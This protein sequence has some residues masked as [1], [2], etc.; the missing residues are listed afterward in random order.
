MGNIKKSKN[1]NKGH[2]PASGNQSFPLIYKI[3]LAVVLVLTLIVFSNT[4]KNDFIVNWDDDGYVLN[5]PTIQH[6]DKASVKEIFSSFHM[7]NYHP[8]TTLTYAIEYDKFKVNPKPY[9]CINLILHLLNVILVF[10]FVKGLTKKN[11][12]ALITCALFAIHPMHVESV[13]WISELKD[14]LYTFF[15]LLSLMLYTRFSEK[16]KL[17]LYF[18]SLVMFFLSLLSKSAAVVLPLVLLLID[19][20]QNKKTDIKN[21]LLK[22]PFFLLAILLGIIALKSQDAQAQHLTPNYSLFN[23]FFVAS[24]ALGF[25]IL[26][27]FIPIQLSAFYPHP[28][29]TGSTLPIIYYLSPLIIAGFIYLTFR[30]IKEKKLILFCLLFLFVTIALVLQFFPVGGAVVADRYTYVPYIGLAFLLAVYAE[31]IYLSQKNKQSKLTVVFLVIV[32]FCSVLSFNRNSVWANGVV[33]FDDVIEKQPDAFYAYHSRGIAYY[34]TGNYTESLK[35]YNKAI[36]L[37]NTYGLTFYNRGL[38]QMML[39][40]YEEASQSFS[41]TIEL[42]PTHDQ[43]YNDRAIARYNLNKFVDAINDYSK[44][45]ELNP[46]NP[47]AFYNRGVTYFRVNDMEN[48][49]ADWHKAS[50]LGLKQANDLYVKHCK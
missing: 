30:I 7:G 4:L 3:L 44:S 39:K 27:F 29:M 8:L 42:I 5:N 47:R 36:E 18:I 34:Y 24:Y 21:L 13:A 23:S 12:A 49:C 31:K 46:Q 19:Y 50:E 14:V 11:L 41:R 43:A 33:L 37:N 15:F 32:L 17:S 40:Q 48:S 1:N 16:N 20:Y 6:L 22:V 28:V 45:I 25:Y 35:D 2:I 10:F 38:T 26:K 9:H